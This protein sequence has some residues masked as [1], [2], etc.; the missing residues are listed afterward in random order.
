[1]HSDPHFL[2]ATCGY[3]LH[4]LNGDPIRCPECGAAND[5]DALRR[6]SRRY[7]RRERLCALLSV[8]VGVFAC[9]GWTPPRHGALPVPP[10]SQGAAALFALTIAFIEPVAWWRWPLIIALVAGIAE[11][12][13]LGAG[14][15]DPWPALATAA[16]LASLCL[17]AG[18]FGAGLSDSA[19]ATRKR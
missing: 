17:Y 12:V 4:G 7:P 8:A 14:G 18:W 13:L 6:P 3:D 10:C 16:F 2:C 15:R 19:R 9:C 1:M 11:V 5:L